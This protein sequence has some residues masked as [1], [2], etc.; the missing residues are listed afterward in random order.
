M[1]NKKKSKYYK[2]FGKVKDHDY[3][4][5]ISRGAAHSM[6]NLRYSTQRDI[7]VVIHNGSSY[8]FHLIIKELANEFRKEMHYFPEDKEKYKSFSIPI[9][10][11]SIT[12]S[13]GE[14][15]EIPL[16]L[17]F[18][19]SNKFMM[20]SLENHV[21]NL[22]KLFVCNCLDESVQKIKIRYDDSNIYTRCK[23]CTKRSKQSI[24]LLKSKFPNTFQ[25]TK[26]NIKNFISLLKKDGYPYEYMN[27]W[28]KFN[29]TELPS[30]D[31][32]YSNLHLN[33]LNKED[34]KHA[35]NV[36]NTFNIKII[37][38]YHDLY[39]NSDTTQL[40]DILDQ[41]RTLCLNE[42]KLDPAYFCTTPGLAFEACL[43]NAEVKLELLT[44]IDMVLTEE[45]GIRG[46]IS[47]TIQRY[48][49]ANNKYIPNYNS[50]QTSNF[51]CI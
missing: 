14:E 6:C 37:G 36:W 32:F 12:T 13:S 9:K 3:H 51:C 35:Q 39:V 16:N 27:D 29:E 15:H 47:Q 48:A 40:A 26:G 25:L 46:G 5:G 34:H 1:N 31:K 2:N 43:K 17:R 44:D 45:K 41:F 38:E 7:P 42:C 20:G 19:D 11:K 33:H 49:S 22:P 23:S 10:H 4:T 8:D 30:I 21:D 18:I 24:D 28:N 50:K